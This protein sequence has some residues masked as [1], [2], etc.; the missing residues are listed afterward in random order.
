MKRGQ[1]EAYKKLLSLARNWL[2]LE[3]SSIE[4]AMRLAAPFA[5]GKLVDVGCGDKPY[6]GIF[7]PHVEEYIGVEYEDTFGSNSSSNRGRAD[8]VY[9]GTLPF[10]EGSV[11][12]VLSNQ[13]AEHVPDPAAFFADLSRV[14][15]PGGRLIV[16]VPFSFRE[17]SA[18][19]DFHRFTKYAL[20]HYAEQNRLAVDLLVPRGGLW[21]AV[22]QKL[23]TYAVLEVAQFG[24]DLQRVG[25]LGFEDTISRRPRYWSLPVVAP[26]VV[27][28]VASA[29]LLERV[30]PYHEDTLGYLLVATKRP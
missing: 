18:P 8:I 19:N 24:K 13:V 7:F 4:E 25:A 5:R 1:R 3:K 26:V 29:R 11:D 16:T 9:R 12:T 28:V 20:L 15:R 30:A 14:L 6:E 27:T 23:S 21:A 2:D 17:H 22:G 10:E